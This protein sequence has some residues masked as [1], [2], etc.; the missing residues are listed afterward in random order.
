MEAGGGACCIA[1]GCQWVKWKEQLMTY[2]DPDGASLEAV[3]DLDGGVQVAGVD[4]SSQAV[5][6]RVADLDCVLLCL[7]LGDAADGAKDLLLHNLHVFLDVGE[8][9]GL[10]E[11][12]LVA[13]A[14]AASLDGG[15]LVL[16]GLDVAHDAIE[17]ELRNLGPLEGVLGKGVA[18]LVL[19]STL[20]EAL[21][22]LVVNALL[23]VDTATGTAALAVVEE[24]TKVDPGNGIV[25][26]GVVKDDVGA[27]ATK[28]E[29]DLL[30]VGACCSLHDLTADDGG[31]SEGNLVNVHVRGNGGTGGLTKAGDDV[32][33]T[34]REASL[35]DELCGVEGRK[36]GLLGGLEDD[37]VAASNGGA[38]LPGPH[39][40]R[41]VPGD[42]LTANSNGLLLDVAEGVCVGVD[43]LALDLVGEAAIVSQGVGREA[44]SGL[45]HC[46][47]LAVVKGLNGSQCVEVGL[48]EVGQL[49]KQAAPI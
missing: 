12:A 22:K 8:D 26:V 44:N 36:R 43:D 46:D 11:V 16:A 32:D 23:N 49:D 1:V 19:E 30:Q 7:E 25:N 38:D 3:G 35:L 29:G 13:L 34:R 2:V 17:L 5:G 4:G 47:G 37:S 39:E 21:D 6:G 48:E 27:L 9:C 42:N 14:L 41:E 10:N 45:C 40:E 18:D 15:T 24:N 28:L 33:D 20:L 31:A